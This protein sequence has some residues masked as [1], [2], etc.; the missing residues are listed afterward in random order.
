MESQKGDVS[1]LEIL[2]LRHRERVLRYAARV[3]ENPEDAQDV[4]QE[5]F[6]YVFSR[7]PTYQPQAKFTTFL[8]TVT[9]HTALNLVKKKRKRRNLLKEH[10]QPF[11]TDTSS[12]LSPAERLMEEEHLGLL[13]KG[14]Q[15]LSKVHQQVLHL[16]IVE[17]LSYEEISEILEIPI[18]TVKSRL[19]N[20]ISQLRKQLGS[21]KP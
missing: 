9:H 4:L 2:Y 5:T 17:E 16:R 15:T 6:Q 14:I 12:D 10:T 21:E 1:C 8:Y 11:L 13:R 3:V 20:G 18:G 19:H 7:L